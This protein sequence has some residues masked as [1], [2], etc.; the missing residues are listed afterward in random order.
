MNIWRKLC[1]RV[2]IK[3]EDGK[4]LSSYTLF[5]QACCNLS[6]TLQDMEALS[7]PSNLRLLVSKLPFK[8]RER[9]WSTSFD[10][11]EHRQTRATF[12]D[13]V[14][15]IEKQAMIMQ[16]LLFGYIQQ[17]LPTKKTLNPNPVSDS[18]LSFKG[19]GMHLLFIRVKFPS[20]KG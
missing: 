6:Q 11:L 1:I 2:Y 19:K 18:K 3:P 13:L 20:K 7:L 14:D 9:W 17:P 12:S 15:F 5:F 16:G 4:V 10:I 8:L